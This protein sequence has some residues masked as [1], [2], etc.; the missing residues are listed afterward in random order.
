MTRSKRTSFAAAI[1]A[2]VALSATG[3]TTHAS[4]ADE[5]AAFR[6]S[7]APTQ[8]PADI[9]DVLIGIYSCSYLTVREGGSDPSRTIRLLVTQVQPTDGVKH[10]DPVIV[11]GENFDTPPYYPGI[12]PAADRVGR[13]VI[14]LDARGV[15]HSRP[16]LDCPE[17][18][19]LGAATLAVSTDDPAARGKFLAAVRACHDRL[20]RTPIDLAAYNVANAAGDVVALA[21]AMRLKSWNVGAWGSSSRIALQL[22]QRDHPGLR[23]MF[24]DSPELPADDPRLT[25]AGDTTAALSRL[26]ADCSA[27]AACHRRFPYAAADVDNLLADLNRH[28]ISR[29][30][31]AVG[32]SLTV[33]F[34][35]A[36]TLRVIRYMLT[37]NSAGC[38]PDMTPGSVPAL[39]DALHHGRVNRLDQAV[40]APLT[41]DQPYCEGYLP[42]CA[43]YHSITTGAYFSALCHDL[44]PFSHLGSASADTRA[45][46]WSA[47]FGHSPYLDVC[48]SWPVTPA[49]QALPTRI[50]SDVPIL[51]LIGDYDPFAS[52]TRVQ[53]ALSGMSHHY[54]VT[55]PIWGHNVFG[56]GPCAIGIRNAWLDSP[57]NAPEATC[58]AKTTG[59]FTFANRL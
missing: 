3:C 6:P 58:L 28:P 35:G 18:D 27:A 17:V 30:V 14:F 10:D 36:M 48:A 34:D 38:C 1:I 31:Q 42:S 40:V 25:A 53:T 32:A 16:A 29:T 2:A 15:G 12:A 7:L 41:G 13:T 49:K 46:G 52:L 59:E 5:P 33:R 20:A 21:G 54:V 26:L 4:H 24:L 51:V 9:D 23:A 22:L 11:V 47:A 44:Q 56:S 39:L 57:Q 50:G 45:A 19:G 43:K 55:S 8:C 37:Q